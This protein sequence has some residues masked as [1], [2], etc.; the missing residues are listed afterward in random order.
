[1]RKVFTFLVLVAVTLGLAACGTKSTVVKDDEGN[2]VV[3]GVTDTKIRVGNTASQTGAYNSIGL[4]F[5]QIIEAVFDEYNRGGITYSNG[6]KGLINGR[7]VEF[8]NIDDKSTADGGISGYEELVEDKEVFALVGH[9]GTWT[10]VPT[11]PKIRDL[12]IPMVH[13]A[14]GANQLYFEDTVGNPVMAIQ[15][16]YKTDGR[17]M[18]ARAVASKVYGPG[19]DQAIPEDAVY[20]IVYSNDDA[21]KSILAG[22]EAELANQGVP[23]NRIKKEII[24]AEDAKAGAQEVAQADVILVASNQPPFILFLS[25][26]HEIENKN[27]PI[28][29]SYVNADAAHVKKEE[30]NVGSIFMNGWYGDDAAEYA[31]YER[32]IDAS[33]KLSKEEKAALKVST[34]AKSG[35]IAATTFLEGLSRVGDKELTWKTFI[36]AMESAPISLLLA[37]GVDYRGGQRIGTDTMSLWIYDRENTKISEVDGLKS[38][39]EILEEK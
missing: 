11:V 20:G 25:E 23:A 6:K 15:P 35:Y 19:Q 29:T 33:T 8:I 32:I 13:A 9:F 17:V 22:I 38:I 37:G 34:H 14:T 36:A 5:T 7:E 28:F 4:P 21:G 31:E 1:M 10:V 18:V 30:T 39:P 12:G 24:S 2:I 16:I 26:L 27:A 3:Q